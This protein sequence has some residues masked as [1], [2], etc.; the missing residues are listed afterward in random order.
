MTTWHWVRHAPTHA[1][2]FVGWR[3]VGADLSDA[4]QIARLSEHLPDDAVVVSSDL[5]RCID[6]ADAIAGARTRLPHAAGLREFHFGSWDGVDFSQVSERHPALSRAYWETPGTATPPGG[7]SWN[8]AAHRVHTA[9][10][11]IARQYTP[12]HVIAVAHFG[13]ILTQMQRAL[14]VSGAEVLGH[15]ID[16]FSVTTIEWAADGATVHRINHLP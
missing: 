13:A 15:K 1:K 10:A 14:G 16:N 2:T 12:K 3:D 4:E 11:Q 6:T 9:A 8:E 5:R 7:E